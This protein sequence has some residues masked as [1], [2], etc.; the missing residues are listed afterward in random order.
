M[1]DLRAV[2]GV[3]PSSFDTNQTTVS[4][5][6]ST[7]AIPLIVS[8]SPPPPLSHKPVTPL[9]HR[10]GVTFSFPGSLH[11]PTVLRAWSF[12]SVI[13]PQQTWRCC[14]VSFFLYSFLVADLYQPLAESF[15]LGCSCIAQMLC[16]SKVFYFELHRWARRAALPP[17][18]IRL[19]ARRPRSGPDITNPRRLRNPL[20]L[21]NEHMLSIWLN[22][23]SCWYIFPSLCLI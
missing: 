18:F 5:S 4:W 22:L 23:H 14:Q 16:M 12:Y 13:Q 2:G 8:S 11:A 9:R 10:T 21:C 20:H 15:T 17:P 7:G 1:T 6:S 3:Q 19:Q